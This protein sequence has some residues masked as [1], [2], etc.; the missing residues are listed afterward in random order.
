MKYL[1]IM[2]L[3]LGGFLLTA[4]SNDDDY[5]TASG[6]TVE[7]GVSEFTASESASSFNVPIKITGDANGPVKVE[8]KVESTGSNPAVPY[9]ERDGV[10]SGNFIVTSETINIPSDDKIAYVQ[11][12]PIDDKDEN[13]S[14]TFT[15]TIVSAEGAT[16]GALNSTLVTLKDNDSTPYGKI[17]G[18]WTFSFINQNGAPAAWNVNLTGYE[19]GTPEYENLLTLEG[20]AG[21]ESYLD[22]DYYEDETTG[23][24]Y[25][26]MI[27]P[28]PIAWY[29]SA[30]YIWLFTGRRTDAGFSLASGTIRGTVSA[31]MKEI[32][33]DPAAYLIFTV[34]NPDLSSILG[35]LSTA[36]G[37]KMTR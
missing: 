25:V 15:I 24:M 29:D 2:A 20:L 34:A 21:R 35:V 9:E 27:L 11:I 18:E 33:F 32:T 8:I 30:N 14:R 10:W 7:M 5:N 16:I 26:E 3:A 13:D 19:E 23:E 28:E 4:C 17:Q 6:V 12:R 36:E 37:I 31:D 22:L 1:K